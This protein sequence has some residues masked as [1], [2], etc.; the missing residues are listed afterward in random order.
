MSIGSRTS[1]LNIETQVIGALLAKDDL[2]D[3]AS[4]LSE[5]AFSDRTNALLWRMIT[6]L[7]M[8]GK[9]TS[10][11]RLALSY[12]KDI[13]SI[14][15]MPHLDRLSA[16][17]EAIITDFDDAVNRLNEEMQWRRIATVSARLQAAAGSRDKSPDQVLS[18]LVQLASD[19]LG[20]GHGNFETKKQVA[21]RAIQQA[22]EDRD[23]VTT[24]I[25]SVDYI[26]QG[27]LQPTRLYG[28]GAPYGRGKTILLGSISDNLN[29]QDVPHLFF[30]LETPPDDIEIR[31][32]AKHLNI[33]ASMI[34]DSGDRDHAEFIKRSDRYLDKVPDN[35]IYQFSPGA[36]IDEIHRTILAA[37]VRYG[38]KGFLL[39]Y[40]QLISGREKGQTERGHLEACADRLAAICR[41]ENM[42]GII[43]AQVDERGHLMVSDGLVRATS[44][45]MRLVR[46]ENESA[47]FF[48]TEKS[49]YT[50]YFDTGSESIPG[51][52]FDQDCGPHFRN[53]EPT[54]IDA[55]NA[56]SHITL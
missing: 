41:R 18:G 32:C 2:Y 45:Y 37:K 48:V 31:S 46:E 29:L 7:R 43:T 38:I 17:G 53:T 44:L 50:R 39:D 40:W 56:E 24:G 51:M 12:P 11:S 9:P 16:Y 6:R 4:F 42:W 34:H 36:T 1:L 54:D 33:N 26:M 30:C 20:S 21:A 3:R 49:N 25:D 10:P 8:D 14:G 5:D 22:K 52:Y 35:T 47:S 55:M 28:I 13:D 15:G 19:Y 23:P 27:G